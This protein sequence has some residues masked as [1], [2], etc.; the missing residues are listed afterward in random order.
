MGISACLVWQ[1]RELPTA[2]TALWVYGAHLVFNALWSVL[3]FGL[4]DPGIAFAEI[5]VLLVSILVTT[6]LFWRINTWAGIL[7]IPYI[8]WVIFAA[9]LNFTIWQLN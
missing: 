1:R 3:F 2:K 9:Y 5:I 7:M 8:V 4:K 6:I